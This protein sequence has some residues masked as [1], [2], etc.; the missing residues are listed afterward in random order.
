VK[1]VDPNIFSSESNSLGR[2]GELRWTQ[3]WTFCWTIS[4]RNRNT[5]FGEVAQAQRSGCEHLMSSDRRAG[6]AS[7]D[8]HIPRVFFGCVATKELPSTWEVHQGYAQNVRLGSLAHRGDRFED[9]SLIPYAPR[10]TSGLRKGDL[11]T[12]WVS[13]AGII[14]TVFIGWLTV[15]TDQRG[16]QVLNG[17]IFGDGKDIVSPYQ[18]FHPFHAFKGASMD[19]EI[20]NTGNVGFALTD[21]R[22]IVKRSALT[23]DKNGRLAAKH[24]SCQSTRPTETFDNF[25]D[26]QNHDTAVSPRRITMH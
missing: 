17:V 4:S 11:Y 20:H 23:R 13:L 24:E 15:R 9:S 8:F 14:V 16:T 12:I 25:F 2:I 21:V 3:C 18:P 6:V 1:S 26:V 10:I 22:F 7:S 5:D 19:A